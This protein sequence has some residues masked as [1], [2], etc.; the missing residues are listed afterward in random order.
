VADSAFDTPSVAKSPKARPYILIIGLTTA[1]LC[2]IFAS[3]VLLW[4]LWLRIRRAPVKDI[5]VLLGL[6]ALT[7]QLQLGITS[8]VEMAQPRYIYPVWPL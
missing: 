4:P 5:W 3:V 7:A 6:V 8:V 2:S 1:Q